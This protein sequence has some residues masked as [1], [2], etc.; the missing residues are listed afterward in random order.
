MN[1]EQGATFKAWALIVGIQLTKTDLTERDKQWGIVSD[2]VGQVNTTVVSDPGIWV[3]II[4]EMQGIYYSEED[5]MDAVDQ[6]RK[7]F[8]GKIP[9]RFGYSYGNMVYLGL[10]GYGQPLV[11]GEAWWVARNI[12]KT[13]TH[14]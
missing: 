1:L 9:I 3:P 5:L 7:G 8:A 11:D 12:I 13:Q 2:V 14:K 4:E 10:N 6:L